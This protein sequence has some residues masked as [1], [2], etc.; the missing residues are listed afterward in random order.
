MQGKN[1]GLYIH[2]PFCKSKCFYCDFNSF[3]GM[4]SYIE[5][6]F[7]ALY[8]ELLIY[9]RELK[10]KIGTIF[11]GGGTPS[12][13]SE[14][15]IAMLLEHITSYYDIADDAEISIETNPGTLSY[16]KL[17]A[18]RSCGI[19]R[20]S[21]GLQAWQD[22]ILKGLGRIHSNEDFL[23][24]Y[25]D[26]KKAGFDNIN[27]DLM[28]GIQGQTLDDWLST[29]KNVI[30][31]EPA[32]LSCYSLKVEEGTKYGKMLE[33]GKL[34]LVDDEID[35]QMY[36]ELINI[37]ISNEYKHYEISNFSKEGFQCR[38]NMVYWNAQNYI[39]VGAGAHSYI[40]DTRY[41][42]IESVKEYIDYLNND[43][44]PRIELENLTEKDK[45]SEHIILGLRL[46]EG[47]SISDMNA[48]FNIDFC[49][50]YSEEI[51]SLKNKGLIALKDDRIKLT[52]IGLDF[53]NE[54][55]MEFI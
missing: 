54:V 10:N 55:Y 26:A 14:G 4:D 17:K 13:V 7:K 48:L 30:A 52:A 6:Y 38:H 23:R 39:G 44:L 8:K 45:L 37:L 40:G 20:I 2:I 21:I 51:R 16:K 33:E 18:Y 27:V 9:S 36:H 11:I 15:L 5:S 12:Y 50:K 47:I 42:N 24:N 41:G 19:N 25:N 1:I 31:L 46:I 34:K 29:V 43:R 35:R 49:I 22:R 3:P 28:F 32:H 53:A